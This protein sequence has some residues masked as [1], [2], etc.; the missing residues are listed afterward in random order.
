M[1]K[2]TAFT[3]GMAA[4][5]AAAICQFDVHNNTLMLLFSI[6]AIV[7]FW[8]WGAKSQR[9]DAFIAEAAKEREAA[10]PEDTVTV[11]VASKSS[12]RLF[13]P[14]PLNSNR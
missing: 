14:K 10:P 3:L 5:I 7:G 1:T 2:G 9:D 6:G 8:R 11:P 4:F 13:V 12:Q